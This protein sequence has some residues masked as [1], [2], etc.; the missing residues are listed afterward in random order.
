M[1]LTVEIVA[2]DRTLWSGEARAVSVPAAEGDMGLLPGHEPVLATLRPG[3]VRVDT[4]GNER[5]TFTAVSGFLS[6]DDDAVTIVLDSGTS[7][8]A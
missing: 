4:L 2:P 1:P 7:A 3:T 6:L 8:S 5:V